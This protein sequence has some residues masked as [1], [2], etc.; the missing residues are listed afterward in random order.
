VFAEKHGHHFGRIELIDEVD[1]IIKRL[2]LKDTETNK[3]VQTVANDEAL[4]LQF[5]DA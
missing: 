4:R 3:R 5:I 1:G 2:R